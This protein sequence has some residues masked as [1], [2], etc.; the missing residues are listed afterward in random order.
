MRL[1][2]SVGLARAIDLARDLAIDL[3][4]DLG[5]AHDLDRDLSLDRARIRACANDLDNAVARAI[6][7]ASDLV[8][9]N[10]L[11]IDFGLDNIYDLVRNLGRDL[12]RDLDLAIDGDPVSV[13]DL[14]RDL[15]TI[16]SDAHLDTIKELREASPVAPVAGR[17][18]AATALLL[19]E[20]DRA[21]YAEEFRSELWEIALADRR[22]RS[23]LAYA[24]RQV[25][26]AWLMRAEL[27]T[28]RR[29]GAAP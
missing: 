23:Q 17:V 13:G 28:P 29:R 12:T 3:A 14:N 19:P 25:K 7:R 18:L 22:R 6:V 5:R 2:P 4:V 20:R 21:R 9:A 24:A 8:H 27:R 16:D 11:T 1:D 26:S 10:D 15:G